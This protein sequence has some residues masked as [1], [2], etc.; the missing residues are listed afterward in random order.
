M[1]RRE[2]L[3]AVGSAALVPMLPRS[4]A[5]GTTFSRSRPG[6]PGWPSES[7]WK[8]LNETVGGNLIPVNFPLSILKTDPDSAEAKELLKNL[9]NPYFVGDQPGLT[10]TLGW[11]DA[12]T[13]QPSVYAVAARSAQDIA[14]AVNFAR[15]NN[16]RLAVKGGGHSYQGTSNAPD[17]L[18]I[19]TRHMHDIVLHDTFVAQG[20]EQTMQP[21]PAV[22]FGAGTIGMQAYQAVTTQAGKY[23]QGGGCTTVGLTGLIQGGGFGSFSKRFGTAATS[24]LEAEVVTADGQIRIANA[25][26]NAD[27]FW[28][29]KGGGGGTFGVVSKLTVRLHELPEF[30]G[31]ANFKVKASSDEAYRQ[32]LRRFVS[33]YRDHLLNE[34]WGEQAHIRPDNVLEI[35]MVFQGLDAAQAKETWQPFLDWVAKSGNC[36]T[37][38]RVVIGAIPAR[39]FWDAPWWKEHWPEVVIPRDGL[40]HSLIDD[41]LVHVI[42]A[43]VMTNDPRPGA[44][45]YDAWWTGDGGQVSWFIWA[46]QSLWLPDSLLASDTQ[47]QRLADALF[48]CSRNSGVELHF[49]KGLAGAPPDVIAAAKDTATNP[50]VLSAFALAIAADAQG[51][52][53]PGIPGHEPSVTEGRAGSQRVDQGMSELRALVPNPGAYVSESNYFEKDFQH[54]YWGENYPRLADIKR[55]YDPE[56]LFIVHNGVGSEGWSRDGFSKI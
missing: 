11:L 37:Q 31:S 25:C 17:S 38:G 21:Q 5:A 43:P 3:K 19:W 18:L 47:Q 10:E 51:P 23:V 53:Y 7:A 46:F 26:N 28:A 32:L 13:T 14:A 49:N 54:S 41:V 40:L 48:A 50:A 8:Q 20:C 34:H 35:S 42:S 39:H 27:L 15:D 29:L 44:G 9:R 45:P 24:L 12:W 22:T 36:S 33:F 1:N 52:A 30:F 4:L 55:K 16:L 2:F 6:G 56:G